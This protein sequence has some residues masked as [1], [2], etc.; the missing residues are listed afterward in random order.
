[1]MTSDGLNYE[2]AAK[3]YWIICV[4]DILNAFLW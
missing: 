1:M 4:Y 2:V 3:A